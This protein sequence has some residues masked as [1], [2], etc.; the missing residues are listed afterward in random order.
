[1]I[2]KKNCIISFLELNILK[3]FEI[4]HYFSYLM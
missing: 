1:M 3:Y 4:P 2:K